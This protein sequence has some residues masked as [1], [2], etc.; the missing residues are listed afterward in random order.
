MPGLALVGGINVAT[1]EKVGEKLV[2]EYQDPNGTVATN[3]PVTV[4]GI[5]LFPIETLVAEE[6]PNPSAAAE[7]TEPDK[8]KS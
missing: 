5:E 1:P 4:V 2:E 6:D 3:V 8:N 7:S